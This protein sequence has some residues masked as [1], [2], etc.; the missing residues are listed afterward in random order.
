[1]PKT[2]LLRIGKCTKCGDCCRDETLEARIQ[3][4][5]KAG[6]TYEII[7]NDCTSF[8]PSCHLT[9]RRNYLLNP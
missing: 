2:H 7:N 8:V 4:Y 1:M 3:A 9:A 5:K 6:V